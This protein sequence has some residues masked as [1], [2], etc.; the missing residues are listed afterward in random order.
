MDN[1]KEHSEKERRPNGSSLF[2]RPVVHF[3]KTLGAGILV[4]L[5]IGISILVLKFFF[6]L[7]DSILTPVTDHLPGREVA[8]LGLAALLVLVYVVG[9][10]AAF[11]VG[12][13]VINLMHRAVEFIPLVKG[14]YGTTRVALQ[15]F[16]ANDDSRYSGVVLIDFPRP[17][18]KSIGLVTSHINSGADGELLAVYI[19]TTPIPSSGFLVFVPDS[20]VTR[21]DLGVDEAMRIVVSGGVLSSQVF[22]RIEGDPQRNTLS[23]Q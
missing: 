4:M 9:L 14:I 12:R 23:N 1:N 17:G 18:I 5:P 15:M 16:S 3:Q 22:E 11:V 10:I 7:L 13:R 8:G 6:D 20:E 19:P 21:T 2:R